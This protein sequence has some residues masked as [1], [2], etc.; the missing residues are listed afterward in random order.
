MNYNNKYINWNIN[1]KNIMKC[2]KYKGD[3]VNYDNNNIRI[4]K[5]E[6]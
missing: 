2:I 5:I 1:N 4:Y 6:Y 3:K